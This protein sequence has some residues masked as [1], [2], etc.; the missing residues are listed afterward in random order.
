MQVAPLRL[1]VE[2]ITLPT[3]QVIPAGIPIGFYSFSINMS[4]ELYQNPGPEVFDGYRFYN[5]RQGGS[6]NKH[7]FG[8]TGSTLR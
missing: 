2:P 7:Q 4:K 1:T 5:M 3:S 6:E 8:A